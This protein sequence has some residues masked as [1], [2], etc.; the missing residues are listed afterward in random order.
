MYS[1]YF[2]QNIFEKV[3]RMHSG[4]LLS[5][6]LS[7]SLSVSSPT[8]N[9]IVITFHT[10]SHTSLTVGIFLV[11][12]RTKLELSERDRKRERERGRRRRGRRTSLYRGS[13]KL[14]LLSLGFV[15]SLHE[16]VRSTKVSRL[17]QQLKRSLCI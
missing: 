6:S 2:L 3:I 11:G 12:I 14:K 5:L 16:K 17:F 13:N 4:F 8:L 9:Y 7:L 10:H 15:D 1:G